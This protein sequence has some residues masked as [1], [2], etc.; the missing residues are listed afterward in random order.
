LTRGRPARLVE[1]TVEALGAAGDG[2][3]RLDGAGAG[4]VHLPLT[5]PG[6]RWRARLVDDRPGR[7]RAEPIEPLGAL[8]PRA[9]P[10]CRHFGVCGGCALQHVPASAYAAF[11][12][13]RIVTALARVGL[14]DRPVAEPL[15]SPPA[16]RRRV[17]LAWDGALG[18]RARRSHRVVA[19]EHCP[20]ARPEIERLLAPVRRA[21]ARLGCAEAPAEAT[22]TLTDA[23]VDL[24]LAAGAPAT[25]AD[26]ETLAALADTADLA[27][28]TL[29][30][31]GPVTIRRPPRLAFGDLAVAVPPGAF[32][33]ATLEGERA[34]QA[35]VAAWVPSTAVAVADLY[36]G[37][38][39]L[40]LPLAR[41]GRRVDL[42]EG[43]ADAAAAVA[44]ALPRERG[45][46]LRRDLARDPLTVAEL[47]RYAAVVL[48]PP[49]AGAA[50][51]VAELARSAVG[52]VV[53][54]S[55]EPASLARDAAVLEAGGLALRE[56]RPIDQFLFAAGVEAVARFTR[57]PP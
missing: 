30:G 20:I 53:Y 25:L 38:G 44:A 48:D 13:S 17:R 33:Q 22:L 49:R 4:R 14:G 41:P 47:A 24:V 56:A 42:V 1:V 50:A 6:E 21:L 45:R 27:A 10:P 31:E 52:T 32:L 35:A 36:A 12:R 40:G 2:V 37:L 39:T 28:V 51:Q 26:R 5:L 43:D 11:K 29:A 3:A 46:A 18:Y 8:A 34:L 55:C 54:A 23:G 19:L 9:T 16:A 15:V 7:A 57:D